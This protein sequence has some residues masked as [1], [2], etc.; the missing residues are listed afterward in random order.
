MALSSHDIC[1]KYHAVLK[2]CSDP[3]TDVLFRYT[4]PKQKLGMKPKSI[5]TL[6]CMSIM[7]LVLGGLVMSPAAALLLA[8]IVLLCSLPVI[9]FGSLVYRLIGI[10]LLASATGLAAMHFT[11]ASTQMKHYQ[12]RG[13]TPHPTAASPLPKH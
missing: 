4:V 7:L 12:Q 3:W 11:V 10:A 9:F 8:A 13:K 1:A 5:R 2:A 6:T